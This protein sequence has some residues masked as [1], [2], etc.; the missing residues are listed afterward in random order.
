MAEQQQQPSDSDIRTFKEF[1]NQY[2]IL[3]EQCFMDCVRDFTT[4]TVSEK[5][6]TCATNCLDKNLKMIQR[7]SMRFQEYQMIQAESSGSAPL[8]ASKK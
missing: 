1:L 5:E 3:A 2:N 7:I 8:Q 4:R 6:E